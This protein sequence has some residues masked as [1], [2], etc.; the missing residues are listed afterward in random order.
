ML[1]NKQSSMSSH[2][3]IIQG[4][5]HQDERGKIVFANDF[6]LVDVRRLYHITHHSTETVRAWQGHKVEAKWFHCTAGSF[7]VKLAKIDNWENPDPQLT[8]ETHI[9]SADNSQVLYI[10]SGYA[11]GFKALKADSSLMVFSD[12]GL[13]ESKNDDFRFDKNYFF[14]WDTL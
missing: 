5:I 3:N 2:S 9:L 14:N 7:L 13:E 8:I 12:K 1:K 6:D 10:P 4:G 11:N